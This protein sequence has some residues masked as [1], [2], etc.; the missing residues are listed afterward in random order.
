MLKYL[1]KKFDDKG[2]LIIAWPQHNKHGKS[3]KKNPLIWILERDEAQ[4]ILD[5]YGIKNPD[6]VEYG[7]EVGP[8]TLQLLCPIKKCLM[9]L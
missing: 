7:P 5:K 4:A 8:R 3:T 2:A 9:V 6:D 1:K